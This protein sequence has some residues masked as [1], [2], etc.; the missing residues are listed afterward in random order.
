[1]SSELAGNGD[2]GR[3]YGSSRTKVEIGGGN[4]AVVFGTANKQNNI[5]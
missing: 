3:R 4:Q 5:Q 1:M 2:G